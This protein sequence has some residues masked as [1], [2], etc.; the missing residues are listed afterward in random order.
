MIEPPP[1]AFIAGAACL[2]ASHGPIRLTRNISCQSATSCSKIEASPPEMPALAKKTSRPPCSPT[3][4]SIRART[5]SSRPASAAITPS[6]A[7]TSAAITV[8]PSRANRAALALPIPEAAPVTIAILPSSLP[9]MH[10]PPSLRGAKRRG[11]PA[12]LRRRAGLLRS[13]RNDEGKSQ[14]H[15]DRRPAVDDYCLAGHEGR[16]GRGEEDGGAGDL[17]GL[18]DPLHRRVHGN[19]RQRLRIFPQRLGEIGPDQP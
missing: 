12:R 7:A 17:A 4:A 19:R 5:S 3:A 16:G 8:A 13:A 15:P 6:P 10:I 1:R 18:A 11:N 2:I 9:L 14:S